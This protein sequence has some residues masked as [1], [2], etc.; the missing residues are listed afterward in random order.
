[1][2]TEFTDQKRKDK[3]LSNPLYLFLNKLVLD[4]YDPKSIP[5]TIDL[6]YDMEKLIRPLKE[7]LLAKYRDYKIT[8]DLL[9]LTKQAG[10]TYATILQENSK[11]SSVLENQIEPVNNMV[12]QLEE[13]E[14]ELK[15]KYAS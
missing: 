12:A 1:M 13:I 2:G 15:T 10:D 4:Y 5:P 8:N 9:N 14:T 6:K 3:D 11:F 7:E